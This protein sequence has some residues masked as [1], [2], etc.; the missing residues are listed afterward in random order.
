MTVMAEPTARTSQM[1]V[2]DF[3]EIAKAAGKLN[4]AVRFEFIDG[5]IGVKGVPDGDHNE[6]VGWLLEECV[7][8]GNGLRPYT[9]DLGLEVGEYRNGRATPDLAFAPKRSFTGQGDW[10]DPAPLAMVVEVTSYDS[11][12]HRRDRQDKPVAYAAAGVPVYL[13]IDR[14]TCVLTA[15]SEPSSEGYRVTR[16]AKF[17]EKLVLPDP[18]GI[19]LDTEELKDYVR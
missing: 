6:I 17:G 10:A 19:G 16:T 5:R 14:D 3:E 9:S 2:E 8:S 18:V 7:Q 11:D 12:T 15:Y 1:T 4:D 13:L